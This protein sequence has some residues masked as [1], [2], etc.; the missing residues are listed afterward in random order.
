MA[1]SHGPKRAGQELI[2]VLAVAAVVAIAAGIDLVATGSGHLLRHPVD[3]HIDAPFISFQVTGIVLAVVV[4]GSQGIAALLL[5]RRDRRGRTAAW[6]ASLVAMAFGFVQ[7]VALGDVTWFHL[8]VL[9][10]GGLEVLLAA[11]STSR[12]T[13]RKSKRRFR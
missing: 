3:I 10:V 5:R 11:A 6:T 7:I 2:G 4:G 13:D 9:G 8:V 1:T 12:D